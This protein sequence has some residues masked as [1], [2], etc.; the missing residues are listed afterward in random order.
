MTIQTVVGNGISEASTVILD[1]RSPSPSSPSSS[2]HCQTAIKST[3]Y[4]LCWKKYSL[5]L[6]ASLPPENGSSFKGNFIF[7]TM[8]FQR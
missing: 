7:Q 4:G 2:L 1:D 8:D 3:S 5:K 6:T